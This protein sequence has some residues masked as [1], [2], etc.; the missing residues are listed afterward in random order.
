M[1]MLLYRAALHAEQTRQAMFASEQ[2][3]FSTRDPAPVTG[4]LNGTPFTSLADAD[5]RIGA[6]LEVF[7]AG[8]YLWIPFEHVASIRIEPPKRLRDLV[9]APAIVRPS[10]GFKGGELGEV[11]LPALAPGTWR[12]DNPQV[13]L[14]RVT[15][16]DEL[17][18]GREVPVGQKLLLMDDAEISLLEV[19]ELEFTPVPS[20]AR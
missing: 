8:E 14:G 13:Q 5:P 17:P 3:P 1:G 20:A 6:R 16:W 18:D 11:L 2:L 7:A 15:E 4:T 9:W 10:R 12:H 19:R